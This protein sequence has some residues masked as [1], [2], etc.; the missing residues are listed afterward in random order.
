M[1]QDAFL[2]ILS[3]QRRLTAPLICLDGDTRV[4]ARYLSVLHGF[5]EAPA[6][7]W[8]CVLPYAHPIEGTQQEQ[9]AILCYELY[10]RY[11]SLHLSWAGSPYSYHTIGSTMGCTAAA[12][13]AVSGMNRRQAGEDFYYLQQLA[14]TGAVDRVEGTLVQPSS[15]AS[16]RAPFGTG[17]WVQRYLDGEVKEY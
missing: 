2:R 5:F 16:H 13:A 3:G 10:L 1:V 12:Y 4:D 11:H 7:R 15:R 9:A 6:S 8:A 17:R 14:K